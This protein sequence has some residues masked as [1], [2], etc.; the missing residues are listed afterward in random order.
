MPERCSIMENIG[1]ILHTALPYLSY[2]VNLF[3]KL[4]DLLSSYLGIEL[5]EISLG[6]ETTTAEAVPEA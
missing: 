1:N 6:E 3:N 4:L 2:V 5:P